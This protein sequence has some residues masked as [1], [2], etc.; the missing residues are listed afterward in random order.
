MAD[1]EGAMSDRRAN[2][3]VLP[4]GDPQ[5]VR[6]EIGSRLSGVR[7][8]LI[9]VSTSE[10]R[11]A[12][13]RGTG[14]VAQGEPPRR[15]MVLGL[16]YLRALEAAGAV[17]AVV[18]PL[19][20]ASVATLIDRVDGICL[21][22]GPDIDPTAYGGA[23]HPELGPTEP[24][25]DAFELALARAADERGLPILAICRGLQLLNVSRGGA[26]HQHLPDVV[27]SKV[28]HRQALPVDL[29]THRVD[30]APT[31]CLAGIVG[32]QHLDVNS[33]HHQ[34]VASPGRGLVPVAWAPDGTVEALEGTGGRFVLAVQW[35]AEGLAGQEPLFEAFVAAASE[36]AAERR[37]AVAG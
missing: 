32:A 3:A 12:A 20:A 35:H 36:P 2:G 4:D 9:A 21:S 1:A 15:D 27:G 8:P 29:A 10:I 25:L 18:P 11:D 22:G 19:G 6:V 17:P 26:L 16:S 37:A 14:L 24:S 7:R 13:L 28:Q 5:G 31:S 23:G 34:A 33:F 30:I